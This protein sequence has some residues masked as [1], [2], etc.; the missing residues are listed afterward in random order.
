MWRGFRESPAR[1]SENDES[2]REK[3]RSG[4][5]SV[6]QEFCMSELQQSAWPQ[7]MKEAPT[8]L[9]DGRG[10]PRSQGGSPVYFRSARSQGEQFEEIN[11]DA[12]LAGPQ[13]LDAYDIA[14]KFE[15]RWGSVGTKWRRLTILDHRRRFRQLS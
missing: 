8:R 3:D 12:V 5:P 6:T 2:L 4:L 15:V 1:A 11:D 14:N 7:K 13:P 9:E 10:S